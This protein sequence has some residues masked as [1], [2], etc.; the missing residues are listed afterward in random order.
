MMAAY[1][2]CNATTPLAPGVL[3]AML[4]YFDEAFFN[5]SSAAAA[6]LL[7]DDPVRGARI[8]AAKLLG[9]RDFAEDIT[10]TS[11]A[12]EANSW[13]MSA[14]ARPGVHVVLSR[15][16][17]PS[18]VRAAR[19]AE[20]SGAVVSWIGSDSDGVVSA[21]GLLDALRPE[22]AL[23]SVMLANNETGVIQPV[24]DLARAV[25]ERCG[26]LF[27]TDATQ[28]VGRLPVDLMDDLAEVDLVSFS[29]HKFHGPKGIGAL[30]ARPGI[31]LPPIVHGEQEGGRRGGTYNTPAAAGLAEAARVSSSRITAAAELIRGRRNGLET[32]LLGLH[33]GWRV[34]GARAPRLPNTIS[35]TMPGVDADDL[36]DRLAQAGVCISTGSACSSG[37]EAASATLV[38]MGLSEADARSTIRISLSAYTTDDE[39]A[40]FEERFRASMADMGGIVL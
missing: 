38:A 23:V 31:A 1:L 14:F 9:S 6:I 12:S 22:T 40:F 11:G 5:S 3:D 30:F 20:R 33:A 10:L 27:H 26:A 17:H 16:E 8:E 28:M 29:A 21:E 39:L 13:V 32:A 24:R 36:V 2:D 4:P 7:N 25:R 19:H 15:M 34:N 37:A 18:L 35:L